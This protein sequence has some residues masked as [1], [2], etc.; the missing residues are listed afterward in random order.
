M[1][2]AKVGYM[3]ARALCSPENTKQLTDKGRESLSA[4]LDHYAELCHKQEW[5]PMETCPVDQPVLVLFKH[6]EHPIVVRRSMTWHNL[7]HPEIDG[8]DV[9]DMDGNQ[10]LYK[11]EEAL[12]WKPVDL[13]DPTKL[14]DYE[15]L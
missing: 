5:Q 4:L 1:E 2:E 15:S 3:L 9:Y 13:F 8:S 14:C 12:C 11:I 6:E 7:F 10:C